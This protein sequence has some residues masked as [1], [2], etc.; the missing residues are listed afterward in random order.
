MNYTQAVENFK[1]I[2][3]GMN[4]SQ[5]IALLGDPQQKNETPWYYNFT[6]LQGFPILDPLAPPVGAQV[7]YGGKVVFDQQGVVEVSRFAWIDVTGPTPLILNWRGII[8]QAPK[9]VRFKRSVRVGLWGAFA[10]IPIRC[11]YELNVST[12]PPEQRMRL[13]AVDKRTGKVYYGYIVKL[14]P[15]PIEL[16]PDTEPLTDE[17][18]KGLA[19]GGY[20]N[21]NLADYVRLPEESTIYDVHMECKGFK[22]NV[23]TIEIVEDLSTPAA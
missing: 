11:Y 2:E 8:I 10:A 14:D 5:V 15:H 16:F 20:F 12:T 6:T 9:E 23:V 1:K 3:K 7:F 21:P 17:E 13:V 19:S 22:S 4:K 18:V